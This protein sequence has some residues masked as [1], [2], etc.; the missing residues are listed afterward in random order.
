MGPPTDAPVVPPTDDRAVAPPTD[1]PVAPP[2]DAPVVPPTDAPV[3]PPT[4]APVIPGCPEKPPFGETCG[5]NDLFCAY[6][7]LECPHFTHPINEV[8][9]TCRNGSWECEE[10][11]CPPTDAP[12]V[13]P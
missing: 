9:C 12:V 8:E 6:D 10:Y 1:A 7:T 4:D 2:T 11:M 5:A 13:P 3:V